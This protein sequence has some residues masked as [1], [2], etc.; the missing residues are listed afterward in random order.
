VI[1]IAVIASPS[2]AKGEAIQGLKGGALRFLD[3]RA[4]LRLAMTTCASADV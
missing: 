1:E 2:K 4:A 3:R